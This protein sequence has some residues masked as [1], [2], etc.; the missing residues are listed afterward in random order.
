MRAVFLAGLREVAR[1]RA[2]SAMALRVLRD[3]FGCVPESLVIVLRVESEDD[4]D[5]DDED[6]L[7]PHVDCATLEAL[8]R[9]AP[10]G[11]EGHAADSVEGL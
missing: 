9:R 6:D 7:P 5:D 1:E 10:S 2:R 8:A 3:V 4:W 11:P